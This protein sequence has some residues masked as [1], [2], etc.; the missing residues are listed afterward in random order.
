MANFG[1]G[2]IL[3]CKDVLCFTSGLFLDVC[4]LVEMFYLF[5][6]RA[7]FYEENTGAWKKLAA[8]RGLLR[9]RAADSAPC[10]FR[11]GREFCGASGK[12]RLV[13]AR[14]HGPDRPGSRHNQPL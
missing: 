10:A 8:G 2:S 4:F 3:L 12:T 13:C 6:W 9:S 11:A 5:A 14:Y 7:C 1:T